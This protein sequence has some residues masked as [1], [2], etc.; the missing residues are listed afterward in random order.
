MGKNPNL[1]LYY[2]HLYIPGRNVVNNVLCSGWFVF[3]INWHV[4]SDLCMLEV[5]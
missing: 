5:Y 4:G 2:L 3:I 1:N